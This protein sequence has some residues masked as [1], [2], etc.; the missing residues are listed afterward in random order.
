MVNVDMILAHKTAALIELILWRGPLHV[1]DGA[2]RSNI[3]F[4]VAM[5]GQAP[6]HRKGCRLFHQRHAVHLAVARRA[7]HALGHVNTVVEID[8][9]GKLMDPTPMNRL[10]LCQTIAYRR[11]HRRVG[12]D[13]RMTRHARFRRGDFRK[14]S[15][16]D[17]FV[18]IAA[19]E[20]ETSDMMSVAKRYGLFKR[21]RL[22]CHVRRAHYGTGEPHQY[23]RQ[24]SERRHNDRRYGIRSW[25]EDLDHVR[26]TPASADGRTIRIVFL[27]TRELATRQRVRLKQLRQ[28]KYL[29]YERQH[30]GCSL[31]FSTVLPPQAVCAA[32]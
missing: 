21:Y 32:T 16:L 14:P 1:E 10:I 18:A 3:I 12:P 17:R 2:P 9:V 25:T 5:A 8:I 20:A 26:G 4:G 29:G 23:D 28:Q 11:Q 7:A 6:S 30:C 15:F 27:S 13:L 31:T 22:V 24:R 19:I